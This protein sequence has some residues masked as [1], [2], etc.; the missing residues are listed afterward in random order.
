MRNE[1]GSVLITLVSLVG[2]LIISTG[3]MSY[4]KTVNAVRSSTSA[5][6]QQEIELFNS[7][8]ENYVGDNVS[9]VQVKQMINSIISQNIQYAGEDG[10]FIVIDASS[11]SNFDDTSL[12]DACDEAENDN[13]Q[14]N[15]TAATTEMRKL[16]NTIVTGN[17]YEIEAF[18]ESNGIIT[19]VSIYE[20]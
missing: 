13:T 14:E 18:E 5:M 9:G 7:T 6:E 19:E 10:K 11:L 1:K 12:S 15:V 3:I 4:N 8:I 17:S 16:S 2:L 20:K